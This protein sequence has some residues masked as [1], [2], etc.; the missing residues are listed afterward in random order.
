MLKSAE[1]ALYSR[2][3][4]RAARAPQRAAAARRR[5]QSVLTFITRTRQCDAQEF[6]IW[7]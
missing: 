2:P 6:G 3:R 1:S 4:A 5:A 7:D